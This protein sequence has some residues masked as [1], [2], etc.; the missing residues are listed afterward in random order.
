MPVKTSDESKSLWS[1][2]FV[3]SR[4]AKLGNETGS[5]TGNNLEKVF[6]SEEM[7]KMLKPILKSFNTWQLACF[8]SGF[9]ES[10]M[11]SHNDVIIKFFRPGLIRYRR[12]CTP[13]W[14]GPILKFPMQRILYQE[15]IL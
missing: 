8:F 7:I 13:G 4:I 15:L 11:M 2:S 5:E 12:G 1:Q 6:E 9:D 3:G 10:L 14:T